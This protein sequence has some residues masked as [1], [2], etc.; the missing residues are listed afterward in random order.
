MRVGCVSELVSYFAPGTC[1]PDYSDLVS[2]QGIVELFKMLLC[3]QLF[4]INPNQFLRA[5]A[6]TESLLRPH[7]YRKEHLEIGWE[8]LNM[9]NTLLTDI[10]NLYIFCKL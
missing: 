7:Q 2:V 8:G 3:F 4:K 5:D 6:E 10:T 9:A 1:T